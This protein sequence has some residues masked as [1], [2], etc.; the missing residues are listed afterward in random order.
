[1]ERSAEVLSYVHGSSKTPLLG[2]TIGQALTHASA[3]WADRPALICPA[4]RTR[5]TWAELDA[6]A[7]DLAAG[8]LSLG[9]KP[10][11]RIGIWSLNNAEW[12]LTQFAAAKAGLILVTINPAYRLSELE[13][14]LNAV[15]CAALVTTRSFKILQKKL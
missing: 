9:L 15:E 3:N 10:G 11:Y 5:L 12:A 6:Q 8:F 2:H 7:E 1:M 13:F 14:A 4:T